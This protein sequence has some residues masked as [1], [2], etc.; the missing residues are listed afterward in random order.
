[1]VKH[2]LWL[3]LLASGC[4]DDRYRCAR[5][6]QC[7]LGEGGRCELDGYCTFHD[8]TCPTR[9]RYAAHA[10]EL[11]NQCFDDRVA[12]ENV[13]AG[14]QTPARPEGCA[15]TVCA[16]LPACCSLAWTDACAQLAQ[17]ACDVRCD[18]RITIS[19]TRMMATEHWDAQW[20]GS[21]W[22][23][24]ARTDVSWLAW[25]G[26][27]P[28]TSTPR[29][30]GATATE[31]FVG[32]T[33]LPI[34]A[35]RTYNAISSIPVDR[36]GSDTV[37]ASYFADP[38]HRIELWDM[39][40]QTVRE[41]GVPGSDALTWGDQNRDE[42]IDGVVANGAQYSYLENLE[43]DDFTRKIVN[44]TRSNVSGGQTP[45]TP[46]IRS[47]DWLDLDGDGLLDLIVFGNSARVHTAPDGLRDAP[48]RD[49]DCDPPDRMRA[50]NADPEPNL[51]AATFAGC[52][53]PT[54]AAPSLVLAVY[55]GR[56][57]YRAFADGTV[58]RIAFP[59]DTCTCNENCTGCPGANCTCTYGC[60]ACVPILAV[61]A[62]DLDG[63]RMLDLVAIDAR[64]QIFT[65]LAAGGYRF[66]SATQ[67]PTMTTG[68]FFSVDVSVTG[69]IL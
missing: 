51:E 14:G 52:A 49:F 56:K 62:R 39:A 57:L 4:F 38:A 25:V 60:N 13:C 55:P 53:F 65:A 1:M 33:H 45:G 3:T 54:A 24:Q 69:A 30:A 37:A 16:R 41:M 7:D 48:E 47:T 66:G 8:I 19:A 43:D 22:S 44:Q 11:T 17:E 42:F 31:L 67:V 23:F 29:L 6:E 28:G 32:D 20:N 34:A 12:V 35:G 21:A 46:N 2:A 27:A 26:P 36:D 5:D 10:G 50:C 18:T 63:D 61:V 68:N 40:T 64:L 15:A 58:A 59:G 9:R